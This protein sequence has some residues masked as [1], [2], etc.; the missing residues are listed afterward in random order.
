MKMHRKLQCELCIPRCKDS[1]GDS[2]PGRGGEKLGTHGRVWTGTAHCWVLGIHPKGGKWPCWPML[3]FPQPGKWP[4]PGEGGDW[5]PS[6]MEPRT[7]V[8]VAASCCQLV[9][10]ISC[11]GF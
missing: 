1:A 5:P 10:E 8:P 3:S 4:G 9:T 6:P 7:R 2:R 11:Q